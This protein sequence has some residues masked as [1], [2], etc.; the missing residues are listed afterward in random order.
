MIS[1]SHNRIPRT[2][3][4]QYPGIFLIVKPIAM[5]FDNH[6]NASKRIYIFIKYILK[7]HCFNII[8]D[9]FK[10]CDFTGFYLFDKAFS[11]N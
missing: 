10:K 2:G 6:I 8:A 9:L 3:E 1:Q 4:T 7:Y 5:Y 11:V